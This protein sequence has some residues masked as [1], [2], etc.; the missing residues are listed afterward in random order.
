[1]EH[2]VSQAPTILKVDNKYSGNEWRSNCH[3]LVCSLGIAHHEELVTWDKM[4][5]DHTDPTKRA[6]H[7]DPLGMSIA[8]MELQGTFKAIKTS[9]YG[10]SCF[11]QVGTSGDF[12]MF[13]E[14]Q[15]TATTDDICCL[16]QEACELAQPN[17]VVT[18][19]QDMVTVI[20]LLHDLHNHKSL[21]WLKMQTDK[22]VGATPHG[23]SPSTC[24]ASILATMTSPIS[25]ISCAGTIVPIMGVANAWTWSSHLSRNS[26]ST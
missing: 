12:P 3:E 18:L 1:M 25:I 17:L 13:P 9:E 4:I 21:Q 2:N 16:L 24:F 6:K 5:C 20:V 14:P 23:D 15:E 26:A 7:P 10:L 22:E 11:Y 19:T 8:Y